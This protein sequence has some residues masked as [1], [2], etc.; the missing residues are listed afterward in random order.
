MGPGGSGS[1][2]FTLS[3]SGA[4]GYTYVLESTTD[5]VPGVW[6]SMATNTLG[7]NGVW[8]Y[9][10]TSVTNTDQKFYRLKLVQ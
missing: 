8:I 1:G 3:L 6:L 9:T 4:P 10:D 2:G 7:T 5:L